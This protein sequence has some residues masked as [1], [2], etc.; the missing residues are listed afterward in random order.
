MASRTRIG[1]EILIVLGLSL[2]QSAVYAIVA[3]VDRA[4]RET[5]IGSQT[6][7][8]NPS[9]SQREVF[10]LIYQLLSIGFALMP[11]ALVAW[12]LWSARRPHLARLGIDATRPGR[13]AAAG[14]RL[15][16]L[17]GTG[18]IAVYLGGRALGVTV[19][20]DPSGLGDTWWTVPV[21]LLSALR[22][23]LEEEVVVVGY[24]FARL[25]DL[26]WRGWQVVAAT[27]VLRGSYHLYQGWGS[28]VGNVLMGLVFGAL[29]LRSGRLLPL[30]TAH[31]LIDAAVF[32]GYPLVGL[33]GIAA[34]LG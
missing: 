18:G 17:V 30:I 12:L 11:V 27:S 2:G 1:L 5:P 6:T 33:L 19:A 29:Y 8:L 22:A 16:L 10:D 7:T 24:L 14:A 13:D 34:L 21:L 28:F 26:G 23:A 20:V 3:V 15:A 32:V 25:R 31:F 9:Y 4:T